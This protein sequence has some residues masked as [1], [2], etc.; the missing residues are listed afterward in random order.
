LL[1]AIGLSA[2]VWSPIAAVS[3]DSNISDENIE[4][5]WYRLWDE[6]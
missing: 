4:A 6:S 1:F 2:L 5:K 3:F